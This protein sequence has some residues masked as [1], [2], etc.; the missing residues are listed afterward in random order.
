MTNAARWLCMVALGALAACAKRAPTPAPVVSTPPEAPTG[1]AA[2]LIHKPAAEIFEAIVNPEITRQFWIAKSSGRLE[3]GKEVRWEFPSHVSAQVL[4]RE[5]VPNRRLVMDWWSGGSPPTRVEWTLSAKP[6]GST[7]VGVIHRGF[8]GDP[9]SVAAQA[10]TSSGGFSLVL[11]GMKALLEQNLQLNL[12]ASSIE[13]GMNPEAAGGSTPEPTGRACLLIH[14]PAAE[15][16]EA[17]VNPAITSKFWFVD[18]TGRLAPGKQVRWEFP[19][20]VWV[21]VVV[22]AFEPNR[23]LALDWWV[24][25]QKPTSLEWVLTSKNDAETFVRVTQ[26]GFSGDAA[27]IAD[28]ANYSTGGFTFVLGWFKA[29]LEH[30]LRPSVFEYFERAPS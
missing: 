13:C 26:S 23:R 25:N 17:L 3:L 12:V 16:F 18:S 2:V 22:R 1:Q 9:A 29:Y 10:N 6:D 5:L 8:Q 14:K 20:H 27:S 19:G 24:G 11:A 30:D 28:Q 4:V 15:V 7:L 21:N